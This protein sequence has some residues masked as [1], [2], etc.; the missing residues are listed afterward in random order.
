MKFAEECMYI[1]SGHRRLRSGA[2]GRIACCPLAG[3]WIN[4]TPPVQQSEGPAAG[5]RPP[6]ETD[7]P[8]FQPIARGVLS[9]LSLLVLVPLGLYILISFA[10]ISDH[11]DSLSRSCFPG[12]LLE[13]SHSPSMSFNMTLQQL[14]DFLE[15]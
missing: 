13:P 5:K 11:P 6:E 4:A 12:F 1:P 10:I 15:I 8:P 2:S 7:P 14:I 3:T 9:V